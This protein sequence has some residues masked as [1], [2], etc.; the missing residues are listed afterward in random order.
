VLDQAAT[1]SGTVISNTAQFAYAQ[2]PGGS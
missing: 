1:I 2:A